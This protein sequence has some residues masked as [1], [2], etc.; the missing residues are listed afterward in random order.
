MQSSVV[1]HTFRAVPQCTATSTG[2]APHEESRDTAC[3]RPASE[4]EAVMTAPHGPSCGSPRGRLRGV[5]IGG[6][7]GGDVV[8]VRRSAAD[9]AT[10]SSI[11]IFVPEPTEKCCDVHRV[12]EERDRAGV[13]RVPSLRPAG[14]EVAPPGVVR[15]QPPLPVDLAGEESLQVAFGDHVAG[16]GRLGDVELVEPGAAPGSLD[17]LHDDHRDVVGDRIAVHREHPSGLRSWT[18][19][20]TSN[21]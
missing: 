19:V 21:R 5:L 8:R 1:G 12:A 20:S 4:S 2:D 7:G 10:A 15:E 14:A 13:E 3:G 11:D 6:Q 18:K 9:S 17:C 16:P